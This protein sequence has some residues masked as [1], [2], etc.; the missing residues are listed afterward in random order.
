MRLDSKHTERKAAGGGGCVDIGTGSEWVM[1]AHA[2]QRGFS[3][4]QWHQGAQAREGR[5]ERGAAGGLFVVGA[6]HMR[7]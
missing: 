5:A 7:Y 3:D 6:V 2:P 1:L 4:I